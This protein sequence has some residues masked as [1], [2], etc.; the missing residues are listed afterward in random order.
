L[1]AAHAGG[2]VRTSSN[3]LLFTLMAMDPPTDLRSFQLGQG[4]GDLATLSAC[5]DRGPGQQCAQA[6]P[7][8]QEKP[9]PANL[10]TVHA[11]SC[12]PYMHWFEGES[13]AGQTNEKQWSCNVLQMDSLNPRCNK[14]YRCLSRGCPRQAAGSGA[15][16]ASDAIGGCAAYPTVFH[17]AIVGRRTLE[18][19]RAGTGEPAARAGRAWCPGG[20]GREKVAGWGVPET[21]ASW[22]EAMGLPPHPPTETAAHN[23][24]GKHR[25]MKA[26]GADQ[27]IVP[28]FGITI[29]LRKVRAHLQ[30]AAQ[31]QRGHIN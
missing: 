3:R 19:G 4:D 14:R 30:L 7:S 9:T 2:A 29:L 11:F 31:R 21:P 27:G 16:R 15:H 13:V 25:R 5:H 12:R 8:T 6:K 28:A 23:K 24:R 20:A 26:L 17:G 10:R 22:I 1:K 18:A